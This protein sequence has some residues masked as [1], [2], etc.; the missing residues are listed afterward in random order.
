M[1]TSPTKRQNSQSHLAHGS[2]ST[3]VAKA[4]T[5]VDILGINAD[6]GISLAELCSQI[7]IPKSTVHRFLVTLQELGLAERKNNDRYYL[8]TKII[9]I[10][11][12]YLLKSDLRN[13]S[14]ATLDE[15][16]EITGETVHLR[17]LRDG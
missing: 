1:A 13:D 12:T 4:I 11:G 14:Q 6:D 17:Y 2:V 16:A 3:T 5:I 15:L 10:A 7:K 8:G 9:E